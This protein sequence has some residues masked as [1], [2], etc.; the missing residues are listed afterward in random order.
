MKKFAMLLAL[1]LL[2]FTMPLRAQDNE[3]LRVGI[4]QEPTSLNRYFTIQASAFMFIDLYLLPPW[5][6]ND[7]LQFAPLLVEELPV[8]V[9]GGVTQNEDGQTVV[10][11]TLADW[12]VWSDGTPVTAEDFIFPF[13]AANDGVSA[14]QAT[15]FANIAS[16]EAGE[17]EKEVVVTFKSVNPDWF[18]AGFTPLPAHVLRE[19]YNTA[20]AADLGLESLEW[21]RMPS[22]ANGPYVFAEWVPGSFMRFTRNEQFHEQP[23]FDE[24]VVNW[25]PDMNVL[26]EVLANGEVDIAHNFQPSDVVEFIGNDAFVIDSKF[27]SGREAWWINLGENGNPALQD[28]RV[29][30]ALVMALD[31]QVIVDEL[32]EGLTS[33]P[34]G[35]WD[36]TPYQNP[37]I[38]PIMYNPEGAVALLNEAGWSDADGDGICEASGVEG[39]E[40]GTPLTFTAGTTNAPVRVDTLVIAQEMLRESCIDLQFEA[41]EPAVFAASFTDGGVLRSGNLD[42][43]QFFG[44][45][46]YESISAT[47][48]FACANLPSAD[49]PG[50]LNAIQRCWPEMDALWASLSTTADQEARLQAAYEIQQ[51]MADEVFWIGMWDRPQLTVYRAELQNVRPAGQAPYWQVAEWT[52]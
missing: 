37:N 5:I 15:T 26:R 33:V 12:A 32:Q 43:L 25:Y 45:T 50:G 22:V 21:N 24:I 13:E 16:V 23:F 44:F 7:E 27:N 36:S 18:N 11:Y 8:N 34:N 19:P 42:I 17:S 46:T 40:D 6:V 29:R 1:A 30:R 31:R 41:F 9:E 14:F 35:F 51:F 47:Q 49:N 52:R 20:I 39:V 28:V 3:V 38:E 2:V 4:D 10:R 48:W